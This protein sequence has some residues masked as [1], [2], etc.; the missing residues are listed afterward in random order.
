MQ[1]ED[2]GVNNGAEDVVDGVADGVVV[3]PV[4]APPVDP[5]PPIGVVDM[6]SYFLFIS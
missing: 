1:A 4:P 6:F 5:V 2:L 3:D